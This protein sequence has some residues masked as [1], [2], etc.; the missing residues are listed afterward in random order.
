MEY[1]RGINNFELD[2]IDALGEKNGEGADKSDAK[3]DSEEV[4]NEISGVDFDVGGF[5]SHDAHVED[6]GDDEEEEKKIGESGDGKREQ[7]FGPF[8]PDA[9]GTEGELE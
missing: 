7:D 8:D 4:E 9:R 3:D 1:R 5:V 2:E 6:K